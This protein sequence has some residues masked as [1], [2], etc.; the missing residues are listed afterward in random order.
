MGLDRERGCE[1][2]QR[3]KPGD[4]HCRRRT[5]VAR[6]APEKVR[7]P[8]C[9]VTCISY[10][11]TRCVA[12]PSRLPSY[13]LPSALS[14]SCPTKTTTA[15]VSSSITLPKVSL[16][17]YAHS[18]GRPDVTYLSMTGPPPGQ[19]GYYP[20][21]PQ[22]AYGQQPYGQPYGQ[23]Y[24][25]QP[26]P[27]TVYVY[28]MRSCRMCVRCSD[29]RGFYRQQQDKGGGS[30]TCCACLAGMCLCCCAE[31]AFFLNY[32]P[33]RVSEIDPGVLCASELCCDCL[34]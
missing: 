32:L 7:L 8:Q 13:A 33:V 2:C 5:P 28:V 14:P 4:A 10:Y 20:Q 17:S 3:R 25:P 12:A 21:Q 9:P 6:R 19:G 29:K 31:G 34:F 26:P 11:K 27:Q 24:Q 18:W 30:D 1:Y 23:P 16:P 22:Q 15:A